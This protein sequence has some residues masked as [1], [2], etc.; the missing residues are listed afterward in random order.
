MLD[1]HN[2]KVFSGTRASERLSNNCKSISRDKEPHWSNRFVKDHYDL[3]YDADP[4]SISNK[5]NKQREKKKGKEIKNETIESP[6]QKYEYS[7]YKS[8]GTFI[9]S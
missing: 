9:I 5:F 2:R 3:V 8:R 6:I 4:Y 7:P 1:V